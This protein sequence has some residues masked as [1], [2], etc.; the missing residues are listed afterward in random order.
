M[1][2]VSASCALAG[3]GPGF[4]FWLCPASPCACCR[5]SVVS[6]RAERAGDVHRL[7]HARPAGRRPYGVS[8]LPPRHDIKDPFSAS[9][10]DHPRYQPGIFCW[11]R[12]EVLVCH[13]CLSQPLMPAAPRQEDSTWWQADWSARLLVVFQGERYAAKRQADAGRFEAGENLRENVAGR[14]T[15]LEKGSPSPCPTL[16][17]TFAGGP[18]QRWES[19]RKEGQRPSRKVMSWHYK[20]LN[21]WLLRAETCGRESWSCGRSGGSVPC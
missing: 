4:D 17:K 1:S 18:V 6:R 2:P 10:V 5:T 14:E 7:L 13:P 11:G 20:N 21:V 12:N 15:F 9:V 16:P 19:P 3:P 8:L